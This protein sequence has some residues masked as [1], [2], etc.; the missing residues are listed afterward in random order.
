M[1]ENIAISSRTL[2]KWKQSL[3]NIKTLHLR[4]MRTYFLACDLQ[5]QVDT[6]LLF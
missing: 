2:M 3:L 4:K 1:Q 5:V 6:I